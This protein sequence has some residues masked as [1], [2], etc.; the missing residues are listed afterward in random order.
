[1]THYDWKEK[2]KKLVDIIDKVAPPTPEVIPIDLTNKVQ[3]GISPT[4][5]QNE[6]VDNMSAEELRQLVKRLQGV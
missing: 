6:D 3:E 1:M 4:T 5:L 2:G